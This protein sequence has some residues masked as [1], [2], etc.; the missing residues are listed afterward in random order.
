MVKAFLYPYVIHKLTI[1][2]NFAWVRGF[3]Y[4][5]GSFIKKV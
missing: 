5:S 3:E 1:K 4:L 2:I